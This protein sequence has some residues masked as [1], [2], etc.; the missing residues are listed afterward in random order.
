MPNKP[1][2]GDVRYRKNPRTF[3]GFTIS[4][5]GGDGHWVV[6]QTHVHGDDV[7]AQSRKLKK[8]LADVIREARE[9]RDE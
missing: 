3:N 4:A 6:V 1:Q 7:K 8:L 9:N 2:L 5:F